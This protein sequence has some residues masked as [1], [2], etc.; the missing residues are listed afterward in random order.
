MAISKC[1]KEQPNLK[2]K[3]ASLAV[4]LKTGWR[5]VALKQ[6]SRPS[7]AVPYWGKG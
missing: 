6:D 1:T 2:V 4:Y 7:K 5:S 3:L